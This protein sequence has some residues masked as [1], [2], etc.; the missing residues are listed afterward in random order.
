[1]EKIKS[2]RDVSRLKIG[3]MG[4]ANVYLRLLLMYGD[5]VIF[6]IQNNDADGACVTIGGNLQYEDRTAGI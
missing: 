3:G 5:S 2:T 1:M 4:L 6:Q